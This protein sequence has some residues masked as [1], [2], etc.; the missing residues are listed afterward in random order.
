[1]LLQGLTATCGYLTR[2]RLEIPFRQS[3]KARGRRMISTGEIPILTF[4]FCPWLISALLFETGSN[5]SLC[6]LYHQP[7]PCNRDQC[8]CLPERIAPR[9]EAGV[10]PL[11][12]GV[13][14]CFLCAPALSAKTLYLFNCWCQP[15]LHARIPNLPEWHWQ[16]TSPLLISF[17]WIDFIYVIIILL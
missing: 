6:V 10:T 11:L 4:N 8:C 2:A 17:I 14:P 7:V 12:S 3:Q 16:S 15:S 5:T 9:K 1:M 13:Q